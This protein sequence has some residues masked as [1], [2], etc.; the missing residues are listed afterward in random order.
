MDA[1]ADCMDA[2]GILY[3]GLP[4]IA[5]LPSAEEPTLFA[6]S[7]RNEASFNSPTSKLKDEKA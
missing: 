3:D 5:A 6:R 2:S 7:F 1:S 4:L